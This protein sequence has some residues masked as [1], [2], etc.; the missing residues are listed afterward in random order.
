[1]S[2][3]RYDF[4]D[5][6]I[7]RS[8]ED[9]IADEIERN[10]RREYGQTNV[11]HN[12]RQG[13]RRTSANNRKT[14][15]SD[16]RD[17]NVSET[18]NA[19]T[20]EIPK[21]RRSS[22]SGRSTSGSTAGNASKRR[23]SGSGSQS[24][25]SGG[26]KRRNS[27]SGNTKKRST[28][29][30][31]N[32]GSAKSSRGASP[33]G[34]NKRSKKKSKKRLIFKLI[35]LI[36]LFIILVLLIIFSVKYGPTIMNW[37]KEA[38]ALVADTTADTFKTSQTSIIYDSDGKEIVELKGDKD[39]YYLEYNQIPKDVIHAFVDVE[40]Q[41]FYKHSGYDI[42][43]IASAS[44]QL[45]KSKILKRDIT[46]GGS[47]ITQQ[48]AKL[49][50]LSSEQSLERKIKEIF[51]S[52][53]LEKK[54]SKEEILEFYIN[55]VFFAN[56]YYGIE[57]AS[58]GYFSKS[59]SK[60]TLA[61][62]AFLCA[63][64]NG[65]TYYN[66]LEHMEHTKTRQKLILSEMLDMKDI[67][68]E[69]YDKALAE[70]IVL[71]PQKEL[72]TQNFETT[73]AINCATKALMSAKGFKFR[74]KF[75]SDSDKESYD[76]SFNEYY[77]NCHSELYTKGYRIYTSLNKKV[78]KALQATVNKQ[79]KAFTEKKNKVYTF[80]GAATCINNETGK[81]VAIVG[82]R[83]QK[84]L[85][86]YTLNRAFQSPR[87][88]GSCFKPIA[89]Y[90]PAI[91][92][93]DY[94]ADTIVDDTYF[95]E[96]PKN[97]DGTYLGKIPL[98]TAVEKS[99]NVVAWRV[100]EDIT[101]EVGLD[102]ILNMDFSHITSD[103][104]I[105][106]ASLGGLTNGATTTE[107]ASAYATLANGGEFCD[108]TCIVKIDD[109]NN[110]SIVPKKTLSKTK[111]IYEEKT[112]S[113]MT[114]ILKGVL[115]RGT[116]AGHTLANVEA[117]GKTGT[118]SD[119]K[120]GWFCGY[121]PYYTTAVWVGYDQPQTLSGLT[122]GSYPLNIW[123]EFMTNLH[124][125]MPETKF[126]LYE[127]EEETSTST[128]YYASATPSPSVSPGKTDVESTESA[129]ATQTPQTE[130]VT[131]T[132][133]QDTTVTVAPAQTQAPAENTTTIENSNNDEITTEEETLE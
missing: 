126:E 87:Q 23:P 41:K 76:E 10:L 103:D 43:A 20:N 17:L 13:R 52:S 131:Q 21:T 119:Y 90:A 104:Y 59:S 71:K 84:S 78:Q 122:G 64:P 38:E 14:G 86:G 34:K 107:M 77:D 116:A 81:V 115:V 67:D 42:K 5:M 57:A 133:A 49:T 124:T 110:N 19:S 96:G 27:S 56:G 128:N 3:K 68:Q 132:P 54:F 108:P 70:E 114:D 106:A 111:R 60:L 66:P 47:T 61:E 4:R 127:D 53:E 120:D 15:S 89:V 31:T 62:T 102:Y 16:T 79:L 12:P 83:S 25:S 112:A 88:P 117:A 82:G 1:M 35:P 55:N 74:Y 26:R 8:R 50:Y 40:D 101:P 65:P 7:N 2:D 28:A 44:I 99:K 32:K 51:I 33:K 93:K 30:N 95:S 45:I 125:G 109:A 98:R 121:T 18:L 69:M 92:E 24:G 22:S 72:K 11:N 129:N 100:F 118:T 29:A 73:Y 130:A 39:T 113:I 80:Q 123:Y 97:A 37:K 94:S 63:I 6:D 75:K 58:R 46:R 9:E 91:N 85:E 48:I 36:I 105:P